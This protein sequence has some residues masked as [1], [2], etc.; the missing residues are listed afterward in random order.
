MSTLR[1][2]IDDECLKLRDP[3]V[4][5]VR[6]GGMSLQAFCLLIR[7]YSPYVLIGDT[8]YA[9]TPQEYYAY[10]PVVSTGTL[11]EDDFRKIVDMDD[12]SFMHKDD[13][14]FV[15]SVKDALPGCKACQ[16]KRF[17]AEIWKLA[18][19]Y[20]IQTTQDLKPPR[21]YPET[22]GEIQPKVTGL[23]EHM[24]GTPRP[25]RVGCMDCVEKHLAQACV[26]GAETV[27][28]YPEYLP[29][30]CAHMEQALDETPAELRAVKTTIEFLLAKTKEDMKP[31]IPLNLVLAL[32][33]SGRKAVAGDHDALM[34]SP[35]AAVLDLDMTD[36]ALNEL[37]AL[38][39][40]S[41]RRLREDFEATDKI[42]LGVE[43]SNDA[44]L[45][46]GKMALLADSVAPVAPVTA[47]IL[48][49]RRLCFAAAPWL[50]KDAGMTCSGILD[51]L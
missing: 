20:G 31:F 29:M 6:A 42:I 1:I 26:L 48:R 51:L 45:W 43:N 50:S 36:E 47:S 34:T 32:I 40:P 13:A 12:L 37:R 23:V 9:L 46:E 21:A 33:E 30:V 4:D 27:N 16:Y 41:I 38:P 28:G 8:I 11:S 7:D 25:K 17:K 10:S 15:K 22:M 24:Y 18:K 35:S 44:I 39:E 19:K 14:A 2:K 5:R 49:N 3:Y